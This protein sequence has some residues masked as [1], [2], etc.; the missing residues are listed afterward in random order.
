MVKTNIGKI[1]K[2]MK[3]LKYTKEEIKQVLSIMKCCD[4]DYNKRREEYEQVF[5]RI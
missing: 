2:E 4:R 3:L 5:E 1:I